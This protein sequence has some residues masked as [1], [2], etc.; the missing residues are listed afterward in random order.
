[1]SSEFWGDLLQFMI[2]FQIIENSQLIHNIGDYP[3][4]DNR[5]NF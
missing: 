4:N 5:L 3:K 1:M 2:Q